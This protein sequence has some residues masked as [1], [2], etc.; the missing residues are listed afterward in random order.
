MRTLA[1][2]AVAV[3]SALTGSAGAIPMPV[4]YKIGWLTAD[5]DADAMAA[6][7]GLD[8]ALDA[9]NEQKAA[10]RP[11]RLIVGDSCSRLIGEEN[12]DAIIGLQPDDARLACQ[13]VVLRAGIPYVA[14]NP[15]A[16]G[17]CLPNLIELGVTP[18]Q[19]RRA[20]ASF[21]DSDPN[22]IVATSYVATVTGS[23]NSMFIEA[24]SQR[25][26]AGTPPSVY[27]VNAGNA[28]RL[29]AEALKRANG[30]RPAVIAALYDGA[31]DG[32]GG[33]VTIREHHAK[34]PIFL[35]R[36]GELVATLDP[37]APGVRCP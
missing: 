16:T 8:L 7:H 15:R 22:G 32:P 37:M 12:V 30:S 10:G 35:T 6:R 21:H 28:L 17:S 34:Q 31:A 20:L 36:R 24:L 18:D 14:I 4:P 26:G 5:D 9:I 2:L 33:L 23:A 27:T 1:L 3:L 25:Y 11:I 13:D 19:E 29:L